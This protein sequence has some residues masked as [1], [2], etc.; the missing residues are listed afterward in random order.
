MGV[1]DKL[2]GQASEQLGEEVLAAAMVVP[3]GATLYNSYSPGS[4]AVSGGGAI[5]EALASKLQGS[6]AGMAGSVPTSQGVLALTADRLVYLKKKRLG[7]GVGARVCEWSRSDVSFEY[8]DHGKWS[9]PGLLITFSDGSRCAVFGERKWG[10][11]GIA[12]QSEAP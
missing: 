1:P 12:A 5:A 8:E 9:Y 6:E 11:D 2:A 7:V 3:P 4:K 10:L